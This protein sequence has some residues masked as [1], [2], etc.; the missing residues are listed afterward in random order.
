MWL[1]HIVARWL[2]HFSKWAPQSA[3]VKSHQ[4]AIVRV[5][6]QI[7]GSLRASWLP[8]N[9]YSISRWDWGDSATALAMRAR[10]MG[11]RLDWRWWPRL[12]DAES[13]IRKTNTKSRGHSGLGNWHSRLDV[14]QYW[15]PELVSAQFWSVPEAA[16]HTRPDSF[17]LSS[18]LSSNRPIAA[19]NHSVVVAIRSNPL[20][21]VPTDD[22]WNIFH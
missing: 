9:V 13:T 3:M 21:L 14:S 11:C 16:L 8:S 12:A 2:L 6:E 5:V 4:L 17:A 20:L 10:C 19:A 1:V 15:L 7:A 22:L 18:I